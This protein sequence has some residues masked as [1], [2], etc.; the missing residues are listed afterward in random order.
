MAKK[1]SGCSFRIRSPCVR[2]FLA[3]TIGMIRDF[4]S[5]ET[6]MV[7]DSG[8]FILVLFGAGSIAQS[9]LSLG[10][11]GDFFSINWG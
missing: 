10:H 3:E 2:E 9:T 5:F 8:T 4:W 7:N 6:D 11:K 1:K